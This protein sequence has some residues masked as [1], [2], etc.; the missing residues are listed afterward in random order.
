MKYAVGEVAHLLNMTPSA[1]RFYESEHI[2]H[3]EKS[4]GGRRYYSQGD[5]A[6]L[7]SCKKYSSM[8]IPIKTIAGQFRPG[9]DSRQVIA[10]RL[11]EK[12]GE[13]EEKARYYNQL[14]EVIREQAGYLDRIDDCL[15]HYSVSIRE[16]CY[17]LSDRKHQLM[18]REREGRELIRQWIQG[19]PAVKISA[20]R[21]P[22]TEG[23]EAEEALAYI[24]SENHAERMKLPMTGPGIEYLPSGACLHTV[25]ALRDSFFQTETIFTAA[26]EYM[27]E[28]SMKQDGVATAV[29]LVVESLEDGHYNGFLE[30]MMPFNL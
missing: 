25:V 21:R 7:I 18:S 8:E 15:N 11:W 26:A 28:R 9:G 17:I 23:C 12:A 6:R 2:I 4:S 5:L 1:L 3:A 10:G 13:M 14:S 29:L 24:V 16:G 22:A 27:Q 20:V 30:I 19:S